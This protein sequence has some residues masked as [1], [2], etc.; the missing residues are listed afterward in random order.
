M[1]S[2]KEI[3]RIFQ[4]GTLFHNKWIGIAMVVGWVYSETKY[5]RYREFD[6][7]V[8]LLTSSGVETYGWELFDTLTVTIFAGENT[9]A[10]LGALER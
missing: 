2:R 5:S 1:S 4:P 8:I 9:K 6:Y 7:H 3:Q 10:A